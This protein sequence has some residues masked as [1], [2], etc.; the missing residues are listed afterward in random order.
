MNVPQLPIGASLI[1]QF[2][3]Q[4]PPMVLVDTLHSFE[5]DRVVSGLTIS[6]SNIFVTN[7][8]FSE[9]G[10]L[11]HIAQTAALYMGYGALKRGGIPKEGYIGAIKSATIHV[12][13]KVGAVLRTELVVVYDVMS[14]LLVHAETYCEDVLIASAEMKTMLK[15]E[16][17]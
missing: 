5:T 14:M 17:V 3:P 13:P 2:I 4:R 11:E 12:I 1:E 10:I 6:E 15:P 16:Q 7:G 9:T 8:F